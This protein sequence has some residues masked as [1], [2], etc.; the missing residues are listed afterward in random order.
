MAK[1]AKLSYT[2]GANDETKKAVATA[3]SGLDN[4]GKSA[5]ASSQ[6]MQATFSAMKV[7]AVAGL[8]VLGNSLKNSV[9][10]F[11]QSTDQ[12]AKNSRAIG[13]SAESYQKLA[14]AADRQ[15]VSSELLYSSMKKLAQGM[16]QVKTGSGTL[17]ASLA[18]TNP[19]LLE[20]LKGAKDNEEAF[21]IAADAIKALPDASERAALSMQIF[22]KTGAEMN[23]IFEAGSDGIKALMDE[24][25]KY[26]V[27]TTQEANA[28]EAFIDAVTKLK[29]AMSALGNMMMARIVPALTPMIEGVSA[30]VANN[31]P[32]IAGI[33]KV[34]GTLVKLTPAII[35]GAGA[36]LMVTKGVKLYT[37]VVGGLQT[38]QKMAAASGGLLNAVLKANPIMLIATGVAL[39]VAGLVLLYMRFEKVRIAVK[40]FGEM[41]KSIFVN[42]VPIVALKNLMG[43][44]KTVYDMFTGKKSLKEGLVDLGKNLVKFFLSPLESIKNSFQAVWDF[45]L[46]IF[47]LTKKDQQ[48]A[49]EGLEAPKVEST[50]L[51]AQEQEAKLN[52]ARYISETKQAGSIDVNFNNLPP[53]V[54][55]EQ[56][57]PIQGVKLSLGYAGT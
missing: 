4:L 38:L 8:A 31:K 43:V 55:V 41:L 44:L 1:S 11:A 45:I 26:G 21:M 46:K 2:I 15:G 42:F 54:L 34:L 49:V 51:Q 27:V 52:E 57:R 7:A 56:S 48:A 12:I 33:S 25:E 9:M 3:K 36:F 18:K 14:Y 10:N 39:A 37:T 53:G 47:S 13:V 30:W 16:G 29:T 17:A 35:A 22:G 5:Q 20:Q 32:L 24:Q 40:A 19:V 23:K 50:P 6:K 28:S